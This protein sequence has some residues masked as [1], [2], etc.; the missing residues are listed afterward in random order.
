[1]TRVSNACRPAKMHGL[2]TSASASACTLID[3]SRCI[4]LLAYCKRA[5]TLPMVHAP[6]RALQ[7]YMPHRS[8]VL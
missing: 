6:L 2:G 7:V 4:G 1:V 8:A 5:Y 3:E